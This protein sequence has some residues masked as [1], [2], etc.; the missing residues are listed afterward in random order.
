MPSLILKPKRAEPFFYGHP[1]VFSGAVAEIEGPCNDGDIV[2]VLTR[3]GQFIARGYYNSASQIVAKLLTWDKAELIDDRFFRRRIETAIALRRDLLKLDEVTNAYR[4]IYSEADGLPGLI[5]DKYGDYLVAQF[6]TLGMEMRMSTVVNLLSELLEPAEIYERS[7]PAIRKKEGLERRAG[8]LTAGDPPDLV[9]IE[10]HGVKFAV[11]VKR[12]QKTGFFLDQR[13]N[14]L[15]FAKYLEGR[16]LLDCFS[17]TAAFAVS[18]LKLGKASRA[19]AIDISKT[20]GGI[21][22]EN[23]ARNGIDTLEFRAADVFDQL[24]TLRDSNQSYD[25]VVLD[26]PRFAESRHKAASALRGYRDLNVLA[27]KLLSPG[28][29]LLTCCCSQHVSEEQFAAMLNTS[30]LDAERTLQI[31]ETR[32][33]S[34]DHPVAAACSETKYLKALICRV[35]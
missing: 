6:L 22:R 5:V 13:D 1:W 28:G 24:R 3:K 14:R 8:T 35:I 33:Q 4:V 34:P 20:A 18:G 31:L 9:D 2:D 19:L 29:V 7:D 32:S 26:P 10:E 21:A 17:Y 25:A 15:A 23:A 11:D 27:F 12:G 16:S 30:A